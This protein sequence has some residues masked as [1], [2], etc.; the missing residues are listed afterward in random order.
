MSIPRE[1]SSEVIAILANTEMSTHDKAV[2]IHEYD[3]KYSC[4]TTD[5]HIPRLMSIEQIKG[6]I[7][8]RNLI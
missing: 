2:A 5:G 6:E 7:K 4:L 3:Y 8:K 1:D